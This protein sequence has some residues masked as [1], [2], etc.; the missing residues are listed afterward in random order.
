M[1][2]RTA[3]ALVCLTG[4][5]TACGPRPVDAKAGLTVDDQGNVLII[6][7]DCDRE[8]NKVTLHGDATG[9]DVA[10][11]TYTREKPVKGRTQFSVSTGGDGW[12]A[13]GV[14]PRLTANVKF[15]L[16]LTSTD[17]TLFG[18]PLGFTIADVAKL[19]PGQV[20]HRGVMD[21]VT[22]SET[23]E[24]FDGVAC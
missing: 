13:P 19:E 15:S 10:T 23:V 21:G 22:L 3:L 12:S 20:F 11:S 9:S 5:L 1:R 6:V 7:E 2:L 8:I 14:E 17:G 16:N 24:E 4:C 18:R